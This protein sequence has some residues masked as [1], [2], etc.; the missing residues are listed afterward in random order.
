[1]CPL[2][3]LGSA[4]GITE[5]ELPQNYRGQVTSKPCKIICN[6][7]YTFPTDYF[8]KRM[9]FL[10][11]KKQMDVQTALINFLELS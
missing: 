1:C 10:D 11:P 8:Y 3:D 2:Q 4:V 7:I 6:E 5:V 9:G